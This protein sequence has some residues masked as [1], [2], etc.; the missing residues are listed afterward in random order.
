[1]DNRNDRSWEIILSAQR[2]FVD[3]EVDS[4]QRKVLARVTRH[5]SDYLFLHI[6]KSERR[7]EGHAS[8]F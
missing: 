6:E 7:R 3:E 8:A 4:V 5:S 1:M 2:C